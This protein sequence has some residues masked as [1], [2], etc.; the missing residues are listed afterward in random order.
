MKT[1]RAQRKKPEREKTILGTE[2]EARWRALPTCITPSNTSTIKY[3]YYQAN[4]WKSSPTP[5]ILLRLRLALQAK[6][7]NRR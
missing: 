2:A 1:R 5:Y 4:Q 3:V 6:C 7:G